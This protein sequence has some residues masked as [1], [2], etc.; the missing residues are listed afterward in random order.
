MSV[1]DLLKFYGEHLFGRFV[2]LYP[3]FFENGRRT[4][5]DFLEGVEDY[6]HVEV[7]KLYPN[8]QLPRFDVSRPD[9]GSMVM[10]YHSTRHLEDVA[11]GLIEGCLK[12]YGEAC[13]IVR[14]PDA[15]L[16]GVRFTLTEKSEADE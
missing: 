16:G 14:E 6:I 12:H 11:E 2:I 7:R 9:P 3:Q 13:G 15:E 8:D 5:F 10:I 4:A 1:P